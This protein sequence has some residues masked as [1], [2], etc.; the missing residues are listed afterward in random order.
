MLR[1]ILEQKEKQA[2]NVF[3]VDLLGDTSADEKKIIKILN[4]QPIDKIA[5]KL[6]RLKDS[7]R[8]VHNGTFVKRYNYI[9]SRVLLHDQYIGSA[10]VFSEN[11]EKLELLIKSAER[12][13]GIF[14]D[15]AVDFYNALLFCYDE[16]NS[17]DEKYAKILEFSFAIEDRLANAERYFDKK[18][19]HQKIIDL[20]NKLIELFVDNEEIAE[21]I[22]NAWISV[23]KLE[24]MRDDVVSDFYANKKLT[25]IYIVKFLANYLDKK[26]D[27]GSRELRSMIDMY[28]DKS[29]E[30][31]LNLLK[32]YELF[33]AMS[34]FLYDDLE[35]NKKRMFTTNNEKILEGI[36]REGVV[37]HI[38]ILDYKYTLFKEMEEDSSMP[39]SFFRD[40][41]EFLYYLKVYFRQNQ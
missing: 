1:K 24:L 16:Q 15:S 33:Y 4:E 5:V 8:N 17:L 40:A 31:L 13:Q 35:G 21:G 32:K 29:K 7:C 37:H 28:W 36:T 41:K 2:N 22:R 25:E 27:M 3:D 26:L 12:D 30:S 14:Q 18:T 9:M 39:K 34:L 19:E 6:T 10:K 20:R 38:K 23:N 11:K